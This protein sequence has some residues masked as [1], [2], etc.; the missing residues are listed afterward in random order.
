MSS[1]RTQVI[2]AAAI[3]AVLSTAGASLVN[4]AAE[5]PPGTEYVVDVSSV[6][7]SDISAVVAASVAECEADPRTERFDGCRLRIP[8]GEH[9]I[10]ET[11]VICRATEFRGDAGAGWGHET[12][13]VA[14]PGITAIRVGD[15]A[16]CAA[17]GID[18]AGGWATIRDL[19]LEAAPCP[20]GETC[21]VPTYGI[22]MHARAHVE[23]VRIDGFTQG[24]RISAG[25]QRAA[26]SAA[27]WDADCA[28]N[29]NRWSLERVTTEGSDHAGV[30][31][32]GPDSNAGAGYMVNATSACANPT[33]Q[34]LIDGECA[35]IIDSSFLGNTWT[36]PHTA[37]GN[38]GTQYRSYLFEGNSQRST[39]VGP[40]AESNQLNGLAARGTLIFG[41]LSHWDHPAGAGLRI[42]GQTLNGSL[43]INNP[44]QSGKPA[45][46]LSIGFAAGP[47]SF[48]AADGDTVSPLRL[49]IREL[50]AEDEFLFDIANLGSGRAIG[51]LGDGPS[52][53][54]V[55]IYSP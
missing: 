31:V 46:T 44:A 24:V 19:S 41:G 43:V 26:C 6:T 23:N 32:D 11:I 27:N 51:I 37:G 18:A 4:T 28:S 47:G 14:D 34:T 53:G 25:I 42:D 38:T 54:D 17:R 13:L 33:A 45:T 52:A 49:K 48:F 10:S 20:S 55:T 35:A 9:T 3:A 30:F 36:A 39:V 12:R 16:E 29:A 21:A 15:S 2:S 40:Y 8:A 5:L 50:A 7:G 22:N 1:N